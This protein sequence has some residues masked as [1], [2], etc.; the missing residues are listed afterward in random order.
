MGSALSKFGASFGEA[1]VSELSSAIIEEGQNIIGTISVL[2]LQ[3]KRLVR[4]ISLWILEKAV[5]KYVFV[6]N[7][8]C[9]VVLGLSK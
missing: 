8:L 3:L 9:Y 6:S 5:R 4:L 2:K 7:N 1:L